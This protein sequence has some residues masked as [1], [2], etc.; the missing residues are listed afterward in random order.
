MFKKYAFDRCLICALDYRKLVLFEQTIVVIRLV[1]L[2]MFTVQCA[3]FFVD[4]G[5]SR[6]SQVQPCRLCD[7]IKFSV[8][9]YVYRTFQLEDFS[10]SEFSVPYIR[11]ICIYFLACDLICCVNRSWLYEFSIRMRM[12][13]TSSPQYCLTIFKRLRSQITLNEYYILIC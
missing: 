9:A 1:V 3:I 13:R 11:S 12:S 8:S 2:N 5:I 10:V 4:F 7:C 6:Y